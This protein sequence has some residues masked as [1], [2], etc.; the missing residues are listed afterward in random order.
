MH[1]FNRVDQTARLDEF[2]VFAR[3]WVCPKCGGSAPTFA[4]CR[5]CFYHTWGRL[6]REIVGLRDYN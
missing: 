6:S 2:A 5:E 4:L 3:Q 1:R